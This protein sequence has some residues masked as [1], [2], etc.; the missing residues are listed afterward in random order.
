MCHALDSAEWDWRQRR[1]SLFSRAVAPGARCLTVSPC[2]LCRL[3]VSSSTQYYVTGNLTKQ[4]YAPDCRFKD[5]TTDVKGAV[6]CDETEGVS[7]GDFEG[8]AI[9]SCLLHGPWLFGMW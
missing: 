7:G 4:L 8:G 3:Y 5:P 9:A 2:G 1:W 6:V